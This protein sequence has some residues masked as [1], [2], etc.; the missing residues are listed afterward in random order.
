M[1]QTAEYK[2]NFA[3]EKYDRFPILV[4]KGDREK[5]TEHYK[6]LGYKSMN[7]YVNALIKN[8]M[9]EKNDKEL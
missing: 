7:Q 4:Y 9:D 5:I 3:K 1:S 2:N 6:K 8:D